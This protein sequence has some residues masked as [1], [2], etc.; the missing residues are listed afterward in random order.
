MPVALRAVIAG[1]LVALVAANVWPVLL[2][3]LGVPLGASAELSF[4]GLYVWWARGGGPPRRTRGARSVAFRSG[5]LSTARWLWGLGAALSFAVT[6]HVSSA[7]LFRFTPF[8]IEDFRRGY[9]FSFIP[10]QTLKWVAVVVSALSAGVCE[11]T[12]FRGYMQ[13]PIEERHGAPIAILTS[14]FAFMLVHLT[15]G[16]AMVGM[17]PIVFFAGVLLGVLAWASRSLIPSIVGHVVMDIGLFAYW[18]TG[19]AGD[20]SARPITETGVDPPF[21]VGCAL[22]SGSLLAVLYSVRKLERIRVTMVV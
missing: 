6:V 9:D 8:P 17:V 13:Q 11:E 20:F 16:W 2:L 19:I 10:S 4:L 18:W 1:L 21:L 7:L 22:L 14:S 5:G 15:K 3:N 12:G